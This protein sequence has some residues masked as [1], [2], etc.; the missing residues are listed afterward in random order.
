MHEQTGI[1]VRSRAAAVLTVACLTVLSLVGCAADAHAG[2]PTSMPTAKV[3]RPSLSVA[4]PDAVF[5]LAFDPVRDAVWFPSMVLSGPKTLDEVSASTGAVLAKFT[6]PVA[7][8]VGFEDSVRVAP[9]GD[10]WVTEGYALIRVTPATGAVQSIP[11]PLDV[12]GAPLAGPE[13]VT[14]NGGSWVSGM[15]LTSRSVLIG[16]SNVPFLQQWSLA[17]MQPMPNVALPAG[18]TT[19]SGLITTKTGITMQV[20]P[21][22]GTTGFA[23]LI[24]IPLPAGTARPKAA[25]G[26]SLAPEYLTNHS[27]DQ[28]LLSSK[29]ATVLLD[30]ATIKPF[31]KWTTPS[32]ATALISWPVTTGKVESPPVSL[33]SSGHL[34][35]VHTQPSLYAAQV[36]PDHSLWLVRGTGATTALLQRYVPRG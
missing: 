26:I 17:T 2:D 15:T 34:V 23:R 31:L 24:T 5:S 16:R 11:L 8:D 33:T 27:G 3:L 10:V 9:D 12:A 6:L 36:A 1:R 22:H 30:M 28:A 4:L 35:T 21:S 14:A 18:D 32:G 13:T 19:P 20:P 29:G 7:Q 25:D